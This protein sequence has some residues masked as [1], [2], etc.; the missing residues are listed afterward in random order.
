[1]ARVYK[2]RPAK[3]RAEYSDNAV[4]NS[5]N[6]TPQEVNPTEPEFIIEE[7]IYEENTIITLDSIPE[8]IPT[9]DNSYL[10][11]NPQ[12]ET[13][14]LELLHLP[15]RWYIKQ[16]EDS[17]SAPIINFY[18]GKDIIASL[19]LT[20]ENLSTLMPVLDNLYTRPN[21]NAG[22]SFTARTK[23]WMKKHIF[24]TILI[25]LFTALVL[26]GVGSTAIAAIFVK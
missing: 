20:E 23:K 1:M 7:D 12:Y 17:N 19:P 10:V 8:I 3:Q 22:L 14:I 13:A 6:T 21:E 26:Y 18:K 24:S 2:I 4:D 5:V 11:E 25:I 9:E 15:D 16:P